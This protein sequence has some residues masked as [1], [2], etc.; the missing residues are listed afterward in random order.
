D[1]L[2]IIYTSGSTGRPKGV[3]VPNKGVAN[4]LLWMKDCFDTGP[5]TKILAKTSISF[6][7]SVWELFLPLI[8]GGTL[9]LDRRENLAS[10][11]QLAQ[12]IRNNDVNIVQFV[13][14]GL[15]LFCEAGM[16]GEIPSVKTIFSGGETLSARLE[17]QVLRSNFKGDLV[18]L[19][20]PTEASIFVSWNKCT[21]QSPYQKVPIGRPISNTA[22]YVLD[23]NL[24]VMPMNVAGDIYIGGDVLAHGYLHDAIKTKEV[25]IPAPPH[26]PEQ[27]LYA[28][29]DKGRLLSNGMFEYLGR[30]DRQVKIRG[31]RVE[32]QEIE[33]LIEARDDVS[34][35]VALIKDY[36]SNDRRLHVVA[37]MAQGKTVLV[38][39]ILAY[40]RRNLPTYMV[41]SSVIFVDEIPTLE[42][43]KTD[44]K[45]AGLLA[46]TAA[47]S[48]EVIVG[49]N[50]LETTVFEIWAEVIGNRE[51]TLNDNFFDIG[52][53]SILFLKV[54]D[55]LNERL[56]TNF[57]IADLYKSPNIASLVKEFKSRSDDPATSKMYQTIRDRVAKRKARYQGKKHGK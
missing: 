56:Q 52:G 10:P 1:L 37:V 27:A 26:I 23:D 42:N 33:S 44:F 20:G 43:G 49:G 54:R 11:E 57:N 12:V 16:M 55:M 29:G 45:K 46:G 22:L 35:A 7:I 19:Y 40:L 6:D 2:Y 31:H 51:F 8:S 48:P 21:L 47:E 30:D 17:A 36:G 34:Q 13:P 53:H 3:M 32:C 14:S 18:N 50:A 5:D 25:F 9:V 41:P 15:R 4:Y 28:T 39:E 24:D 38:A